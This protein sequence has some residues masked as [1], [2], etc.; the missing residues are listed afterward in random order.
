[1]IRSRMMLCRMLLSYN[2]HQNNT[3][4]IE[5]LLNYTQQS[6]HQQNDTKLNYN[7]LRHT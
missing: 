2:T 7:Y 6:Y 3:Q 1:M 4:H 5:T